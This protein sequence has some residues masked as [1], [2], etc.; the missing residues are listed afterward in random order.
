MNK[1]DL[2]AANADMNMNEQADVA[3]EAIKWRD[4]GTIEMDAEIVALRDAAI[5]IVSEQN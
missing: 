1:E 2:Y 5:A 4:P 3:Y